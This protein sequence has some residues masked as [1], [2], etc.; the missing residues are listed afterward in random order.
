MA[1]SSWT[2]PRR[3]FLRGAGVMLGLP[4]LEAMGRL[5]SAPS[6]TAI[7]SSSGTAQLQAPVRMACL[8]FPN[9]VWERNWFPEEPGRDYCLPPS[10]EPLAEHRRDLLVF[11]GLDK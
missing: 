11:S 3:T 7:A 4:L 5:R 1:R 8:Y 10:L 9:G 6:P 2:I